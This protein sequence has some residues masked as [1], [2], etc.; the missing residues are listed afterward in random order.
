MDVKG[1]KIKRLIMG[2]CI[3]C[4]LFAGPI[5]LECKT[6]RLEKDPGDNFFKESIFKLKIN[7]EM[8][9]ASFSN[10]KVSYNANAIF[11]PLSI[12]IVST[13]EVDGTL[14]R[15]IEINRST[16]DVYMALDILMQSGEPFGSSTMFKG[17]C[18]V[19]KTAGNKI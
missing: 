12:N 18:K 6:Q 15:A 14:K 5:Y 2:I 9:N 1:N 16:L 3:S 8:N 7:E 11:T 17:K 10:D 4:S 13:I 19:I